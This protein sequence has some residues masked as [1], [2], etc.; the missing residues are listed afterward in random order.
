MKNEFLAQFVNTLDYQRAPLEMSAIEV[1]E[2]LYGPILTPLIAQ[3]NG[4]ITRNRIFRVFGTEGDETV[5]G[6]QEWNNSEWKLDY[7]DKTHN[8]LFFAEDIFGNQ[9]AIQ[10]HDGKVSLL[11]FLCEGGDVETVSGGVRVLIDAFISPET[12]TLLD[13][14][15]VNAA[16]QRGLSP[17][18]N[19]HLAF[20]M[21][22]IAGG[23]YSVDNIT[24]ENSELHLGILSQLSRELQNYPTGMKITR[25]ISD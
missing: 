11:R 17:N 13:W 8:L 1:G 6:I 22:L 23:D 18:P 21:P 20:E 2:K 10:T 9:Y 24:V 5:P 12:S 15:L 16:F 19:E 14:A 7:G 3:A 25:F 4:F